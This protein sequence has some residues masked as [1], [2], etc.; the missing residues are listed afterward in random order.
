MVCNLHNSLEDDF[1]TG[2]CSRL[3][4]PKQ[5]PERKFSPTASYGKQDDEIIVEVDPI[6]HD[7]ADSMMKTQCQL[8]F[9]RGYGGVWWS[10]M[11]RHPPYKVTQLHCGGCLGNRGKGTR[12]PNLGGRRAGRLHTCQ[13][14][15]NL[16]LKAIR[17]RVE[18]PDWFDGKTRDP[19]CL[20][21]E[22][23]ALWGTTSGSS[24]G[25]CPC[26]DPSW[27][28]CRG[29]KGGVVAKIGRKLRLMEWSDLRLYHTTPPQT[30]HRHSYILRKIGLRCLHFG[31][32]PRNLTRDDQNKTK[33][34]KEARS[35]DKFSQM[36]NQLESQP[37]YG[38][39]NGSGRCGDDEPGDDED[40]GEDEE[41]EDDS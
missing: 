12:K 28:K 27:R 16:G 33:K 7:L 40:G 6:P 26:I 14:T 24:L 1:V 39:G 32:I 19:S 36:L 21:G 8:M 34:R 18:R 35:D 9:A 38:G 2:P 25:S 4:F 31:M 29:D 3:N 5:R 23:A 11:D 41:D 30:R 10:V 17:I 22:H 20:S 15:R 37:E 13:E